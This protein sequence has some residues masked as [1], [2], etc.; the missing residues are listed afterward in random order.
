MIFIHVRLIGA[1]MKKLFTVLSFY[2]SLSFADFTFNGDH[3]A[4]PSRDELS[5]KLLE[6][7]KRVKDLESQIETLNKS[8]ESIM[9]AVKPDFKDVDKNEP[10]SDSKTA[11]LKS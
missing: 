9:N 1:N 4:T 3:Q 2:S 6:T 11:L 8:I 5:Q 10:K 7:Q